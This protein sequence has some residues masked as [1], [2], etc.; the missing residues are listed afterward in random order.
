MEDA[1]VH[2]SKK[3]AIF[4]N[5]RLTLT[6]APADLTGEF[7]VDRIMFSYDQLAYFTPTNPIPVIQPVGSERYLSGQRWGLMPYWGKSSIYVHR[8]SLEDKP[9]LMGMLARRRC[10]IPCSGM[11]FERFEG[12]RKMTYIRKHVTREVFGVAGLFDVWVDSEK[13]EYP[14]CTIIGLDAPEGGHLPLVLEGEALNVWLDPDVRTVHPVKRLL[15][16]IAVPAFETKPA[17][18]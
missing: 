15:W 1:T 17:D 10:V 3:V 2:K 7:R 6:T 8:D 14:M 18:H 5:E 11:Y 9:Y 16:S 12:N 4:L 13:R